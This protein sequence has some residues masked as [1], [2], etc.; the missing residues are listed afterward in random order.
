VTIVWRAYSLVP[1]VRQ[2]MKP[3]L[4]ASAH[5]K[6]NASAIARSVDRQ[7]FFTLETDAIQ[8]GRAQLSGVIGF[9]LEDATVLRM[10]R[11]V[12]RMQS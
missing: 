12:G 3:K 10:Q 8:V 2:G 5:Y 6:T 11:F 7:P 4:M 1:G 9:V